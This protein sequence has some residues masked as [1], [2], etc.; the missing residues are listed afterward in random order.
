[1]KKI[2]EK[3]L[4]Y[5]NLID[6]YNKKMNLVS[7][8]NLSELFINHII[9]SISILEYVNFE[10]YK[11]VMDLGSGCGLPGIPLSIIL[12]SVKFYLVESKIK[13]I[14]FLKKAKN[15]LNLNN[16][17][18]IHS[19]VENCLELKNIVDIILVRAVGDV[20]K[21]LEYLNSFIDNNI[22]IIF[23]KG[24]KVKQE[25][26]NYENQLKEAG[27]K[28]IELYK[29]NFMGIFGISHYFLLVRKIV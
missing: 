18:I 12:P 20:A 3:I 23:Y 27:I 22:S 8:K 26:K 15:E 29:S 10:N 6:Y 19:R 2:F 13:Y 1:M 16:L 7:Y 5:I 28:F 9:D 24:E 4:K 25:L 17:E 14:Q 11:N 21:V